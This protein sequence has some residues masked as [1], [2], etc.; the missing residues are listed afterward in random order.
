MDNTDIN[1]DSFQ[2]GN[3]G[4]RVTPTGLAN[5]DIGP[6]ICSYCSYRISPWNFSHPSDLNRSAEA[7]ATLS[8]P[9]LP[10]PVRLPTPSINKDAAQSQT[11][12]WEIL[13]LEKA[14]VRQLFNA[15]AKWDCLPFCIICEAPFLQAFDAGS[16]QFCSSAL[17]NALLALAIR[18]IVETENETGSPP[19]NFPGSKQVFKNVEE[20]LRRDV[21]PSHLPDIQALGML[22]IY[23]LSCGR[24]TEA[25][26]LAQSFLSSITDL[27]DQQS[28]SEEKDKQYMLVCNNTYCGATSL[29]RYGVY[30]SFH[31]VYM[32]ITQLRIL[33]LT[34]GQLCNPSKLI[35]P[36]DSICLDQPLC[37]I[38]STGECRARMGSGELY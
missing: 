36:Q 4:Q 15:L 19:L 10:A 26:A 33:R 9:G 24:E 22:S 5:L 8:A 7:V 32:L 6:K 37:S 13:G 20:I 2:V 16:S 34:C 25:Q 29:V 17:V 28:L 3:R 35:L 31:V 21:Q 18:V 23:E 12:N 11:Q 1:S 27:C 38:M 14:Y 30:A